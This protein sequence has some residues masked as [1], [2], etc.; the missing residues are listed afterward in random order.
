MSLHGAYSNPS[1]NSTAQYKVATLPASRYLER[2]VSSDGTGRG[3]RLLW[4]WKVRSG[5]DS[6]K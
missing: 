5:R 1:I 2:L 4:Y 6:D 3:G